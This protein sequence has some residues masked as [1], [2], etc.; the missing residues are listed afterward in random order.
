MVRAGAAS[1]LIVVVLMSFALAYPSGSASQDDPFL[2]FFEDNYKVSFVSEN[3]TAAATYAWPRVVFFHTT[4]LLSPNFEVGFPIFHPFN[5]TNGDGVFSKSEALYYGYLDAHHNVTWTLRPTVIDEYSDGSEYALYTMNASIS[6][7]SGPDEV[8]P[9]IEGWANVTFNFVISE[10]PRLSQNSLGSYF[11]DGK[12]AMRVNFTLD[13]DKHINAT[14]LAMEHFLKGGGSTFMFVL[15][16]DTP[17]GIGFTNVSSREDETVNGLEFTHV[18][19]Q[20]SLPYQQV[21]FAKEDGTVQAYFHYDSD[22]DT[23]VG[24]ALQEA[25]MNSSYYTTG[26]GLILHTAFSFS[27]ETDSLS[28][29][30]HLGLDESGFTSS[31]EDWL[32]RNLPLILV[33]AGSIITITACIMFLVLLKRHRSEAAKKPSAEEPREPPSG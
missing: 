12:I 16:E 33:I 26:D 9:E 29:E 10:T 3:L 13:I 4:D 1:A 14:G 30:S 5:D 15:K 27:N 23:V 17:L 8:F 2:E 28:Y 25:R 31:V 21:Q 32:E 22:P 19:N 20:T 7:Y 24:G 6:L 11:V 18:M